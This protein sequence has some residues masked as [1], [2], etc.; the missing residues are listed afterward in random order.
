MLMIKY[1][2]AFFPATLALISRR[3]FGIIVNDIAS[4]D[5]KVK[6]L[7]TAIQNW[8]SSNGLG[9][10]G[11][12]PILTASEI[13]KSTTRMAITHAEQ[14][15]QL[16]EEQ[17]NNLGALIN[18]LKT[19]TLGLLVAMKDK[20]KDFTDVGALMIARNEISSLTAAQDQYSASLINITP[21]INKPKAEQ[22]K[23]AFDFIFADAAQ[24]YST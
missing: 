17:S 15:P 11:A 18:I 21:D 10:L 6:T 8:S 20:K 3:D 1:L 12:A 16:A 22:D 9:F 4:I 14:S 7:T 5:S 19:D 13:V 24:Y 2:L 23:A